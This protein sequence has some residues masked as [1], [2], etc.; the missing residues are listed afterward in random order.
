MWAGAGSKSTSPREQGRGGPQK[1]VRTKEPT[2]GTGESTLNAKPLDCPLAPCAATPFR[3]RG[4]IG[5]AA[6]P[7]P[8]HGQGLCALR[9]HIIGGWG[10]RKC[11]RIVRM[12]KCGAH[13]L[14]IMGGRREGGR[15]WGGEG[16][17]GRRPGRS[18]TRAL[19]ELTR[20]HPRRM[21]C[22]TVRRWDQA[23]LLFLTP[24]FIN[25]HSS[26]C[27]SCTGALCGAHYLH[28]VGGLLPW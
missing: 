7:A 11:G 13:Y 6:P 23:S 1:G 26:S 5:K 24:A 22:R 2:G 4:F 9:M 28:I 19:S 15:E 10:M 14:H 8:R 27:E 3:F 12:R 21:P 16:A 20:R 18:A 25:G 17:R